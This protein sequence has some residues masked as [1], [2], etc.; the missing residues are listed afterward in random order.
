VEAQATVTAFD[1]ALGYTFLDSTSGFSMAR[2]R[3]LIRASGLLYALALV[4]AEWNSTA[5]QATA[6]EDASR[7]IFGFAVIDRVIAT[8]AEPAFRADGYTLR[9]NSGT[10]L[11]FTSGP[12]SISEVG[13]NTWVRYEGKRNDS[14]EIVLSAAEFIKPKLHQPK[15]DPNV[16]VTQV[17]E[18]PHGSMIDVDGSFRT[19]SVKRRIED[20]GGSCGTGWYPVAEN[21]E[22][23]DRVRRIGVRV[24]PQYQRDLPD[25]DPAKVPFRFYAIQEGN[26]RL[27]LACKDGLVLVP[28]PVVGRMHNDS[29]LAAVLADAVAVNLQLQNARLQV[30][31]NL[32]RTAEAAAT[33]YAG[34]AGWTGAAIATHPFLRKIEEQRG[35]MAL[36]L[37][38]DGGFDPW[39][40]PEAWRMLAPIDFPKH[41]SKL[42]YP[43][44]SK[45][46]LEILQ[47][48]YK[49]AADSTSTQ[50]ANQAASAR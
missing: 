38:A 49:T 19:D 48:Q 37:M 8:G 16:S 34:P 24:V 28:T 20:A 32:I 7:K 36:A 30:D 41:P 43:E 35:R 42:K 12:A 2:T 39:Q 9:V 22:L 21:A 4:L 25:N 6:Q 17:T 13:T 46:Q 45:Y 23:Q 15:R 26:I 50:T 5:A 44:R 3:L 11:R 1:W 18:F 10:S 47:L 27:A 14:G 31:L 40:A 33:V 29:E